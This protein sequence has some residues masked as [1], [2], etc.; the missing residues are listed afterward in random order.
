M[1]KNKLR[2]VICKYSTVEIVSKVR[3][4]GALP[5]LNVFQTL[6]EKIKAD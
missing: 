4:K 1:N 5:R 3:E 2:F 6:L